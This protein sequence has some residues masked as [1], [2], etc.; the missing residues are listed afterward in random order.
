MTTSPAHIRG[1]W[2]RRAAKLVRQQERNHCHF[3][4]IQRFKEEPY[5]IP[6]M[7]RSARRTSVE[8]SSP[9]LGGF[10]YGEFSQN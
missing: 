10:N 9:P 3:W 7:H 2:S 5:Q 1:A 6:C 8:T 4:L